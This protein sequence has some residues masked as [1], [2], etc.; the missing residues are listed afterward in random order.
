MT[1]FMTFIKYALTAYVIYYGLVSV[2][3]LG[4]MTAVAYVLLKGWK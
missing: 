4:F 1:D 2:L 3:A